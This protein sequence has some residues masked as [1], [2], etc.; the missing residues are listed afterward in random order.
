M[1]P[2]IKR[3]P[4]RETEAEA[5]VAHSSAVLERLRRMC[6]ERGL[7]GLAENLSELL[8]VA[9]DDMAVFLRALF[10]GDVSRD[11]ATADTMLTTVEGAGQGPDLSGMPMIPG[12]YRMGVEGLD[13]DGLA[14]YMHTGFW[15]TL[16]VYM[17]GPDVAISIAVTQQQ[18]RALFRVFAPALGVLEEAVLAEPAGG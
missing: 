16:A 1:L 17:P 7:D 6:A 2:E 15:G 18:S 14:L 10:T 5:F 13:R 3:R 8:V 9:G 11:A 4:P 12:R